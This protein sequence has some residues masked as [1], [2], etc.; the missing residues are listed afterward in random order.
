MN[1]IGHHKLSRSSRVNLVTNIL[2]YRQMPIM[3]CVV[4]LLDM[5]H[6]MTKTSSVV[7][8]GVL[9]LLSFCSIAD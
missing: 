8:A 3:C 5:H 2:V 1:D 4:N 9:T 7:A 6:V